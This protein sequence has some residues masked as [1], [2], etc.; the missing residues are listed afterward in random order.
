MEIVRFFM[1][2]VK[3]PNYASY[4]GIIKFALIVLILLFFAWAIS[5]MDFDNILSHISCVGICFK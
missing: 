5:G 1:E 3:R 4:N 2:I